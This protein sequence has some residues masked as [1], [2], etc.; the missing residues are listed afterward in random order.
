MP[1]SRAYVNHSLVIFEHVG[2]ETFAQAWTAPHEQAAR[3][4]G[5]NN[6]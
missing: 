6:A 5:P 1:C 3:V 4:R 2:K